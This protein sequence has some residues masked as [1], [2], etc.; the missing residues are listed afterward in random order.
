MQKTSRLR[1][2]ARHLLATT[3]LTV[4]AAGIGQATTLT[5]STDFGNTFGAAT[6]APVGTDVVDG[7]I[8]GSGDFSDFFTFTG[9]SGSSAF[10]FTITTP[11]SNFFANATVFDSFSNVLAGPAFFNSSAG[12]TGNGFVPGDGI[13]VVGVN[14]G[15]GTGTYTFSLTAPQAVPEPSTVVGLGLGLAGGLALKRRRKV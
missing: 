9:L 4:A 8:S 7:E 14:G 12:G 5:E 3:C 13:L 1:K 15:E 6:P 2:F 10:S 11:T